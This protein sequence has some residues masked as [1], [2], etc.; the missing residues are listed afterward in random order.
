MVTSSGREQ[1]TELI[2]D[3]G[4]AV[5]AVWCPD[6]ATATELGFSHLGDRKCDG[7]I[8]E[9]ILSMRSLFYT[10]ADRRRPT[11]YRNFPF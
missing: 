2:G 5:S 3:P 11:A 8:C 9:R 1:V 6:T 10:G 4:F 7:S